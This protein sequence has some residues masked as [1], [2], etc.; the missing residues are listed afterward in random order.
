MT[1]SPPT[2][3]LPQSS[4]T[5]ITNCFGTATT[6]RSTRSG[7]SPMDGYARMEWTDEARGFTG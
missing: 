3:A 7:M 6:A 4:A 5:A 1:Q 2:P